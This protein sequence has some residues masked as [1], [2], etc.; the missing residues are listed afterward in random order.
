MTEKKRHEQ[1]EG[2]VAVESETKKKTRR[3]RLFKVLLHNDNYTT[4]EFVVAVLITVFN[5]SESDAIAIM[6]HVHTRG[7]GV[8]G[9]FPH[10]VAEAKVNKVLALAREAG[11]PL[12]CT[13][14]PE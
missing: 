4:M 12:L 13:M 1:E 11:Y 2:G 6:L 14:E 7:V 5:K 3:P 9:L 8:A 10:D